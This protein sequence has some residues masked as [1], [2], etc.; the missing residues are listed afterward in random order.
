M[1]LSPHLEEEIGER[2]PQAG[3]HVYHK[4]YPLIQSFRF[5]SADVGGTLQGTEG[6]KAGHHFVPW[7]SE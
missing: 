1:I 3:S 5:S 7:G 2:V 4:Q 6:A